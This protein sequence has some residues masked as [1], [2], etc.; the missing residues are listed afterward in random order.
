MM[1][2]DGRR[3]FL[4]NKEKLTFYYYKKGEKCKTQ[5]ENRLYHKK[6]LKR[7]RRL[8]ILALVI[9]YFIDRYGGEIKFSFSMIL[10]FLSTIP[11]TFF[12]IF[13]VISLLSKWVI[14]NAKCYVQIYFIERLLQEKH[15]GITHRGPTTE[16]FYPVMGQDTVSGYIG[17]FYVN[18]DEYEKSKVGDIIQIDIFDEYMEQ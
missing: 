11:I 16:T 6:I 13:S 18:G 7:L 15:R 1:E 4:T 3:F 5:K 2:R 14:G 10:A 8:S 17:K 9:I 12:L